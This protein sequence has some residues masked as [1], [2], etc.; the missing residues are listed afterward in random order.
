MWRMDQSLRETVEKKDEEAQ[1][2]E[3][4]KAKNANKIETKV[5]IPRNLEV[6]N[7]KKNK[8]AVVRKENKSKMLS[9][10]HHIEEEKNRLI[11]FLNLLDVKDV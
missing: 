1:E 11:N 4:A 10:K 6:K 9:D 3:L 7:K 2:E 8:V 5:N